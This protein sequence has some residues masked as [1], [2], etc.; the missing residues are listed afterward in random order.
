MD[1]LTWITYVGVIV[2]LIIF[3]GPVAL[4][5]TSHGLR[6]GRA[7]GGLFMAAGGSLIASSP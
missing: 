3:P 5:C 6:F 2:A 1:G 4:L 7:T